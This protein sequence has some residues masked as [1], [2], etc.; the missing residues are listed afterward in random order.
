[1]SHIN[2]P[3]PLPLPWEPG[4]GW[5]LRYAHPQGA[6]WADV[7]FQKAEANSIS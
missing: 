3:L 7:P 2:V 5:V 4:M 1:M 6:P